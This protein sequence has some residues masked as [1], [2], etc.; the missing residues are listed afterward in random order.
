MVG[1]VVGSSSHDEV[2]G[3]HVDPEL[4]RGGGHE[5][6]QLARLEQVFDH[7][8]FLARE[9]FDSSQLGVKGYFAIT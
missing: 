3:S 8:A 6:G 7:Q 2:D 9:I 1:W 4:E 5:T